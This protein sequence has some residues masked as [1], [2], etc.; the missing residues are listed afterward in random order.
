[1]AISEVARRRW[2]IAGS[3]FLRIISLG[4]IQVGRA[5]N[6]PLVEGAGLAVGGAADAVEPDSIP[7]DEP[8]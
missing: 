7:P 5:R 4:L 1:M 8:K 6:E 2:R 3:W